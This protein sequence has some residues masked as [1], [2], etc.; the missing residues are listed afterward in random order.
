MRKA[1]A[2]LVVAALAVLVSLAT[3]PVR[4]AGSI[5]FSHGVLVDFQRPGFEESVEPDVASASTLFTSVPNGFSTTGSYIWRSSDSGRS[6]NLVP[7]N[8]PLF[9]PAY[10]RPITCIG[11]GDND[12]HT[13][14]GGSLYFADLQ[15]FSNVSSSRSD[16]MG[17]TFAPNATCTTYAASPVDRMWFGSTG[18]H[19]GGN[20]KLF[21]D[22]DVVSGGNPNALIEAFSTD[23][24]TWLP[25]TNAATA[26]DCPAAAPT[27]MVDNNCITTAEGIAGPQVVDPTTGAVYVVHTGTDPSGAESSVYVEKGV[28]D[29]ATT[30]PAATWTHMK[31]F[32]AGSNPL[33]YP[34][35]KPRYGT[36]LLIP[37]IA[38]DK[39]GNVYAVWGMQPLCD[40]PVAGSVNNCT[41]AEKNASDFVSGPSQVYYSYL[42][43]GSPTWSNPVQ[44]SSSGTNMLPWVTAGDGGRIDIAYEHTN[45]AGQGGL[46]LPDDQS[47]AEWSVALSQSLNAASTRPTFTTVAATEYPNKSGAIC[48]SGTGCTGDRSLGDFL[49]VRTGPQGQAVVSYVDDTDSIFC[50]TTPSAPVVGGAE[51]AGPP[52][53]TEQ[54]GG[55]SLFSSVGTISGPGNGPGAPFNSVSDAKGDAAIPGLGTTL[56]GATTQDLVSADVSQPDATHLQ[57]R[58]TVNGDLT[59]PPPVAGF[60]TAYGGVWLVRFTVYQPHPETVTTGSNSATATVNGHAYYLGLELPNGGSPSFFDGDMTCGFGTSHCKYFGYPPANTAAGTIAKNADGTST[61]TITAPLSDFGSP[62]VG[63]HL[64]SITATAAAET[65]PLNAATMAGNVFQV[66]DSTPPFEYVITAGPTGSGPAQR[67]PFSAASAGRPAPLVPLGLVVLGLLVAAAGG[68]RLRRRS[69]S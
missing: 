53:V 5:T 34:D 45:T 35:G 26:T 23:G 52:M 67:T 46:Y 10:G 68:Y 64:F 44:V 8:E 69:N 31:V 43:A 25:V 27:V 38:E 40:P 18:S 11:G 39:A 19:A 36:G 61:V 58:F 54:T 3:V 6:F 28:V 20:L 66:A 50:C 51:L 30:P 60:G 12:L 32:P 63:T 15:G 48:T 37:S 56:A 59:A 41:T 65:A 62:A 9:A 7:G 47:S 55:P 29:T 24:M 42:A 33:D 17:G 2:L 4:A 1:L 14:A 22:V 21:Q 13:D 16:D 57:A 49:E